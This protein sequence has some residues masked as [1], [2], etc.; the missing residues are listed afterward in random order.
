MDYFQAI[1]LGIVQ[2]IAEWLPVSSKAM[3]TLAG[4]FL[5][6]MGYKDA[7]GTAVW[8]HTGT[9]LASVVYFRDDLIRIAKS[10][11]QKDSDKS[12]AIFLAITTV[13]TAIIAA[14]LMFIA[15]NFEIP[16]SVFTILIGF[17]LLVIAFLHKNRKESKAEKDEITVKNG[18]VAGIAQ[19][20]A[21]FPGL[22]RSGLT[23][24]ALLSEDFPLK[25]ALRISFLMSIPVVFGVEMVLP[26]LK[27]G[28]SVSPEM[29]AGSIAAAIVGYA[30]IKGLLSIV[31]KV[32]FFLATFVLGILILGLGIALLF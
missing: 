8:L 4:H 23:V 31:E 3:V 17:F 29:V 6:G 18:L 9:L 15:L 5:F 32:N 14:P 21:G 22:S 20:L 10:L 12:L 13:C 28:F 2:G 24:A 25:D 11:I 16:E 7:F 30:T 19:G 26:V 1:V 27:G